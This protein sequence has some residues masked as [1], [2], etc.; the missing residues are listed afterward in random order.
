MERPVRDAKA[1]FAPGNRRATIELLTGTRRHE[2]ARRARTQKAPFRKVMS[3]L[4][5][6]PLLDWTDAQ[7]RHYR[8]ANAPPESEV[9]A[10]LHRSGECNCGSFAAPGERE[11]LK[12]LWRADHRCS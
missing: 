6:N 12:S 9:A 5:T 7:M 1:Q 11:Q 3:R 4:W 10:L 8:A 2:S